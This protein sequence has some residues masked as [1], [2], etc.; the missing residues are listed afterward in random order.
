MTTERLESA[1]NI[2]SDAIAAS[3]AEIAPDD[4]PQ[5]D[6]EDDDEGPFTELDE[7][8]EAD[9][10]QE[11]DEPDAEPEAAKP[12]RHTADEWAEILATNPQRISEVPRRFIPDVYKASLAKREQ[13]AATRVEARIAQQLQYERDLRRFVNAADENFEADPDGKLAWLQSGDPQAKLY[14]DGKAYLGQVDA[15]TPQQH[16]SAVASLTRDADREYGRLRDFP[17]LQKQLAARNSEGRYPPNAEGLARL[18]ED[19]DSLLAD[20][21]RGN[22]QRAQNGNGAP[23]RTARRPLV[24]GGT[25]PRRQP[26]GPDIEKINDPDQLFAMGM[27]QSAGKR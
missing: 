3:L 25:A 27:A 18:R 11:Q 22:A 2:F 10:P 17:D 19:V 24:S 1:D 9:G 5:P 7:E 15:Q 16:V 23:S 12:E 6:P 13:E 20:A 4:A 14:I 8:P 26:A 21:A